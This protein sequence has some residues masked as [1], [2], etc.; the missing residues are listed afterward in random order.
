M[1]QMGSGASTRLFLSRSMI[2]IVEVILCS[3]IILGGDVPALILLLCC[4]SLTE[5]AQVVVFC[6]PLD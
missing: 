1:R 5:V 2:D 3:S 4:G 6:L